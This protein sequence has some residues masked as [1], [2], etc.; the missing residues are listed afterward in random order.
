MLTANPTTQKRGGASAA[1]VPSTVQ[2]RGGSPGGASAG[3]KKRSGGMAFVP[4]AVLFGLIPFVTITVA[5]LPYYTLPLGQRLRSAYHPFLKPSGWIGQS[6]GLVAFA[7][8]LFL[9]LYPIRKRIKGAPF[10]GPVPRWL[11]AHI[12]AGALVPFAAALHAGFRFT[13][14]I[15]L[16]YASMLV[17]ALSGLV[18]RY[19]YLRIPRGRAGLE[20]TREQASAER[21]E[22]LGELVDSTG[23]DPRQLVDLLRPVPV[24]AAAGV[25]RTFVCLMRDDLDRRRA[26]RK[27]LSRCGVQRAKQGRARLRLVATLAR[28]EMALAQQVRALDATSRV[29]RLWHAFHLP[30]AIMAFLAVTVHVVVVVV[31]GATWL[32]SS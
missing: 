3:A 7:L 24:P 17:V 6:A 19:V 30:F 23:L 15:G 21:R 8:F 12:V 16:G 25:L 14:L 5:G 29:F 4:R 20:L 31:I 11:D 18:G 26:I 9:W 10:L 2:T 22:I 28:R 13:G 27:L 1:S 32:H